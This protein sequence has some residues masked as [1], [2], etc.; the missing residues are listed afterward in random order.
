MAEDQDKG[1]EETT[2]QTENGLIDGGF[3]T[4][5]KAMGVME[6]L[7]IC[8]CKTMEHIIY[9]SIIPHLNS[10]NVLIENQHGFRSQHSCVT[11]LISLLEDLSYSMD[12]HQQTDVSLLDFA[13]AFDSVPHQRLLVKLKHYGITNNICHWISTWLTQR[14]QQVVLD[15][16]S[17]E[18]VSVQS[19][20]PQGTVFGPLMFLIYINDITE[21]IS[22]P[23]RLFTDDCI[24]YKTITTEEDAVQLQNDLDHLF[25]WAIKW[26]LHF[27]VTKCII[28]HFT[29]S[30]SPILFNY[31]LNDCNLTTSGQHSYLG[32]L[33]DN[34][35]SWSSHIKKHSC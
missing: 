4:L 19:G 15:G 31:K 9:H 27:N 1:Q 18:S 28:M 3:L 20:V 25:A 21:S 16:A 7:V 24:L 32:I 23:L 6:D 30:L 8:C 26:Q 2:L 22:S 13:K 33:L 10:F 11:Q 29:R 34:K 35:L 17:S 12:H 14:S 5:E